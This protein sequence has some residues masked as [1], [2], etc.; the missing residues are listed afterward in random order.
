MAITANFKVFKYF[1][2]NV[3]PLK[4]FTNSLKIVFI[5]GIKKKMV[6]TKT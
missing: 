4:L 3:F 1:I 2:F 6:D 5:L